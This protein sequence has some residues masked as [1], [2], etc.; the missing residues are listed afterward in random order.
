MF[1]YASVPFVGCVSSRLGAAC[2]C[3]ISRIILSSLLG[4][5]KN[6]PQSAHNR[7]SFPQRFPHCGQVGKL[8]GSV[9]GF[10]LC[11]RVEVDNPGVQGAVV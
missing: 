1:T 2:G 4:A 6:A 5:Y 7:A 3:N 8:S 10:F 9:T 11:A